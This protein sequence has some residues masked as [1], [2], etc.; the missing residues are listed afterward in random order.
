MS[1]YCAILNKLIEGQNNGPSARTSNQFVHMQEQSPL[2]ALEAHAQRGDFSKWIAKVFGDQPLAAAM[3]KVEDRYRRGGVANLS[4][5]LIKPIRDRY[6]L[7][8]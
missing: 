6:E 4:Q 7:S 8:A 5:A 3:R 2:E 1:V